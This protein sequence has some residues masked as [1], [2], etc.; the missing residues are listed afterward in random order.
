MKAGTAPP[1]SI[2]IAVQ[3]KLRVRNKEQQQAV[4]VS[5]GGLLCTDTPGTY[6]QRYAIAINRSGPTKEQTRA[7]EVRYQR[8]DLVSQKLV[9]EAKAPFLLRG[10]GGV[11]KN[12]RLLLQLPARFRAVR[13]E[14]SQVLL[15]LDKLILGGH[16]VR[17]G[18]AGRYHDFACLCCRWRG[19]W[20][21]SFR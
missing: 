5:C 13:A 2:I 6:V 20:Q 17:P 7:F 1:T 12:L 3:H 16:R 21:R 11:Q 9:D 14:R 8:T 10:G 4:S 15:G 18:G 19:S